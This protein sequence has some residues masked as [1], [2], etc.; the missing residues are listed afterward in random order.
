MEER[1]GSFNAQTQLT[2]RE[3]IK[4]GFSAA[5]SALL[6]ACGIG[7]PNESTAGVTPVPVAPQPRSEGGSDPPEESNNIDLFEKYALAPTE[8]VDAD[9][10]PTRVETAV[11]YLRRYLDATREAPAL[12]IPTLSALRI[13]D[14]DNYPID[15]TGATVAPEA[16]GTFMAGME[17]NIPSETS[18]RVFYD[19]NLQGGNA[20]TSATFN[21]SRGS[22]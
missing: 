7:L 22:V 6:A 19:P 16:V 18:L 9:D 17:T 14:P 1:Y 10:P 8:F 20:G 12:P 5:L 11:S 4:A 21:D 13:V 3:F 2:R 15:I